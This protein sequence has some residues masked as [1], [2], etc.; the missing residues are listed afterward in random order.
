LRVLLL[1]ESPPD[2]GDGERRFFY[3]P[4]LSHD[5]LYRGVAQ[6]LY[7]QR[8]DVD[9]RDKERVL[10]LLREDGFWLIDAVEE[11]IDKKS[12][13]A[14][15]AA[16]GAAAPR[17][18]E[19]CVELAPE[20]GVIVCHAVVYEAVAPML[21]ASGVRVLHDHPLPFPLGNWR[22]QFVQGVRGSLAAAR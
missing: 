18:A 10:E 14:R 12:S 7:G 3:S 6:A 13:A 15:R 19:R 9:T 21:R 22:R 2:P 5:N 16:I 17:L 11:P 1:A 4:R 8:P 20:L